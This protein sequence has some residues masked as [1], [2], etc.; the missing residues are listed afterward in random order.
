MCFRPLNHK[1]VVLTHMT[2]MLFINEEAPLHCWKRNNGLFASLDELWGKFLLPSVGHKLLNQLLIAAS[3]GPDI[4]SMLEPEIMFLKESTKACAV[5]EGKSLTPTS[6]LAI[7]DRAMYY[8]MKDKS[9][10]PDNNLN[11]SHTAGVLIN[12][13]YLRKMYVELAKS[14]PWVAP[15]AKAKFYIKHWPHKCPCEKKQFEEEES[16]EVGLQDQE[17]SDIEEITELPEHLPER[18]GEEGREGVS[19]KNDL[20]REK[21]GG[22]QED[23]MAGVDREEAG[24]EEGNLEAE[25][26]D[27]EELQ[28]NNDD[29]E[30]VHVVGVDEEP[31]TEI[32]DLVDSSSEEEDESD[33]DEGQGQCDQA[34]D[35]S[36][37][38]LKVNSDLVSVDDSYSKTPLE[39]DRN[40]ENPQS[41]QQSMEGRGAADF[42]QTKQAVKLKDAGQMGV[43]QEK[44]MQENDGLGNGSHD[45]GH[46]SQDVGY[47]QQS[48][49]V[50]GNIEVSHIKRESL[51]EVDADLLNLDIKQDVSEADGHLTT[52]PTAVTPN[53]QGKQGP[54]RNATHDAE[55]VQQIKE[56]VE[57]EEQEEEEEEEEDEEEEGA[58]D[59]SESDDDALQAVSFKLEDFPRLCSCPDDDQS[60]ALT[61]SSILQSYLN[62]RNHCIFV[63][64]HVGQAVVGEYLLYTFS[65]RETLYFSLAQLQDVGLVMV[66]VRLDSFRHKGPSHWLQ[67]G[68]PFEIAFLYNSGVT[69]S[70]GS[71]HTSQAR[72]YMLSVELFCFLSYERKHVPLTV[73]QSDI[74]LHKIGHIC[75][76]AS[77]PAYKILQR[78]KD[79]GMVMQAWSK[80]FFWQEELKGVEEK[81]LAGRQP[82]LRVKMADNHKRPS[83]SC[84]Q[85]SAT[86]TELSWD[87]SINFIV[88]DEQKIGKASPKLRSPAYKLF[89]SYATSECALYLRKYKDSDL[90][91]GDKHGTT[92]S[93]YYVCT[94]STEGGN[95]IVKRKTVEMEGSQKASVKES[96]VTK[97]YEGAMLPKWMKDKNLSLKTGVGFVELDT[98]AINNWIGDKSSTHHLVLTGTL[99]TGIIPNGQTMTFSCFKV[100]GKLYINW[101]ELAAQTVGIGTVYGLARK[102]YIF[103]YSVPTML[104][105]HFSRHYGASTDMVCSKPWLCVNSVNAVAWLGMIDKVSHKLFPKTFSLLVENFHKTEHWHLQF[106]NFVL[107][108]KEES[109]PKDR[110]YPF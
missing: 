15:Y 32:I 24:V 61:P 2:E 31:E 91:L 100:N 20:D 79:V 36:Q 46:T 3:I 78:N 73:R 21:D 18:S 75:P 54:S 90:H 43:E 85:A 41:K 53:R 33:Y 108:P 69:V 4:C 86:S 77:S 83:T 7:V 51:E 49:E 27:G 37:V 105:I 8:V 101:G 66:G 16:S 35:A 13:V 72:T 59:G 58:G 45:L 63:L 1:G 64:E 60:G 26:E 104:G 110:F 92:T 65:I 57:E 106:R 94:P 48:Q 10:T 5:G 39:H 30:D 97:I 42:G 71:N 9:K 99:T 74:H 62:T 29:A 47:L 23:Q 89:K 98:A 11:L 67:K 17:E 34:E 93:T 82:T 95:S 12:L 14:V 44:S 6:P 107:I 22:H 87:D 28:A 80:S 55:I 50:L 70:V 40:H 102:L 76:N 19:A 81:R 52:L 84:S 96:G 103:L 56:E 109:L 25:K 88:S 68:N 38:H